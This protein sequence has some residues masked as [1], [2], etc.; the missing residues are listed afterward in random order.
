[1][2]PLNITNFDTLETL[3]DIINFI[4]DLLDQLSRAFDL[5]VLRESAFLDQFD[6]SKLLQGYLEVLYA[7]IL[8]DVEL[9]EPRLN[10]FEA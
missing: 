5:D 1:M 10:F 8:E 3:H 9:R 6:V 7:A 2:D 4:G